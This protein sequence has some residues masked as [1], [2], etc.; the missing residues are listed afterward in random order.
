MCGEVDNFILSVAR[1]AGHLLTPRNRAAS[2][3]ESQRR[4]T[5]EYIPTQ[6]TG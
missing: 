6:R 3:P 1:Q 2:E 4:G 5:H